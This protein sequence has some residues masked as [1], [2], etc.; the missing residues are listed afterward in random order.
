M[1]FGHIILYPPTINEIISNLLLFF[2][3]HNKLIRIP[4]FDKNKKT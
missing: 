1:I 3:F 4:K 2:V